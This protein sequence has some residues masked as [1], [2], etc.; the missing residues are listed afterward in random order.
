MTVLGFVLYSSRVLL[1]VMLQTPF[2]SSYQVRRQW[3]RAVRLAGDDAGGSLLTGLV[4]PRRLLI[5]ACRRR[6]HLLGSG[7]DLN[8]G[9]W[10]ILWPQLLQGA[11]LALPF[12]PLTTVSMATFRSSVWATPP[13]CSTD[14][15]HRRQRRHRHDRHHPAAPKDRERPPART[16]ALTPR[17]S[18][19]AADQRAH[20]AGTDAVRPRAGPAC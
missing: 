13:A 9:Y 14:A 3:C 2:V 4:D 19:A 10:E 1:P 16:S 8:G 5:T 17:P 20:G 7:P 11:G 6:R 15:Q 18:R 12:V